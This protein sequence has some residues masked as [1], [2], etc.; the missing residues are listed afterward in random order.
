MF[1]DLRINLISIEWLGSEGCIVTFARNSWKVTRGSLIIA[2]G[3]NIGT[4]YLC[5]CNVDPSIS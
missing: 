4:L 1:V 2:K 5:T 3:E